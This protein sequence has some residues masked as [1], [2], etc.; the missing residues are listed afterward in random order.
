MIVPKICVDGLVAVVVVVKM[1]WV[2]FQTRH[3]AGRRRSLLLRVSWSKLRCAY[4]LASRGYTELCT[5][6]LL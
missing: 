4:F 6:M 5:M 2:I 1:L 3:D